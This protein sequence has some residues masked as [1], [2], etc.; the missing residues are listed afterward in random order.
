MS[1]ESDDDEVRYFATDVSPDE[2]PSLRPQRRSSGARKMTDRAG[3]VL[4]DQKDPDIARPEYQIKLV[5]EGAVGE[6]LKGL[7][8]KEGAW[9]IW[10]GELH[11]TIL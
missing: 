4:E 2:S 7:W 6:A 5:R 1:E 11:Y 9:G 3:Y 8:Q 10:K